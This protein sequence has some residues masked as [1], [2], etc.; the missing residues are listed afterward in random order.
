MTMSI[1]GKKKPTS[2]FLTFS[3]PYTVTLEKDYQE[4]A[5]LLQIPEATQIAIKHRVFSWGSTHNLFT[6]TRIDN[7]AESFSVDI[8]DHTNTPAER[9]FTTNFR[10]LQNFATLHDFMTYLRSC[11]DNMLID[12][13]IG[14][15]MELYADFGPVVIDAYI[16]R[17]YM[18]LNHVP[19]QPDQLPVK[20]NILPDD[21]PNVI[22]SWEEIHRRYPYL[23]VI[24]LTH[25]LTQQAEM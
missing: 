2:T 22:L 5:A 17:L 7:G 23:W 15:S 3:S 10:S 4:I 19:L 21:I 1:F 11:G 18:A 8:K 14:L 20:K 25:L 24:F 6:R 13:F 12:Q 9:I 16:N